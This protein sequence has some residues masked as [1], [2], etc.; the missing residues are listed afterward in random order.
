MQLDRDLLLE[1]W[2]IQA[3]DRVRINLPDTRSPV[4]F[5]VLQSG[6]I[7]SD[8]NGNWDSSKTL[9][10]GGGIQRKMNVESLDS[11]PTIGL[12]ID[13]SPEKLTTIFAGED[14]EIAPELKLLTRSDE[15]QS[16]FYPRITQEIIQVVDRIR[17]CP[18]QGITRRIYLQAKVLETISLQLAPLLDPSATIETTPTSKARTIAKLHHAREIIR[19]RLDNPPTHLELAQQL[20]LS[21]RTLRRGFRS[22]FDTT[23]F[24]YLTEQ[25]LQQAELLLR[26]TDRS[27][28]DI[29]NHVGYAHLGYFARA[30]KSK[31]GFNPSDLRSRSVA[32]GES[33]S[34]PSC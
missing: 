29:A 2:E 27:V 24:G 4:R 28:A 20:D 3:R 15:W 17:H 22:L 1:I 6:Q 18:Y 31:Y 10:S 7:N 30:F 13:L 33:S 21:D 5:S 11:Q 32:D 23:I 14:G 34:N 25:R 19:S 12:N 8:V 9:I 26:N 16:L